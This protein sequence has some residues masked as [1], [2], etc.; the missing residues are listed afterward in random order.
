MSYR[1]STPFSYAV[2]ISLLRYRD[3]NS[4]IPTAEELHAVDKLI[5]GIQKGDYGKR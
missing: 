3:A 4:L 2:S 5:A 1:N